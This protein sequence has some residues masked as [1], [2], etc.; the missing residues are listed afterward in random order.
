MK[1]DGYGWLNRWICM[2][3]HIWVGGRVGGQIWMHGCKDEWM[4]GWMMF[5]HTIKFYSAESIIQSVLE[6]SS[7]HCLYTE[8]LSL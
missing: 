7:A 5:E 6:S 3:G 1:V 2:D 4:D 8:L